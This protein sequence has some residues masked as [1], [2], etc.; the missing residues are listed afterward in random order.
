VTADSVVAPVTAAALVAAVRSNPLR[1]AE[2]Q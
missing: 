2:L 1:A